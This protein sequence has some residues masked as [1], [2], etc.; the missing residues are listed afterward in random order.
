M[1][2]CVWAQTAIEQAYHDQEWCTPKLDD[3]EIFEWLVLELMQAGLSWRT[4]L[5]KR[6]AMRQAF[7]NF[8]PEIIAQ[9][10]DVKFQALME[11]AG[12][13]RN[14]LKIQSVIKNAQAYGKVQDEWG[15]FAKYIWHFVN[16]QP[17]MNQWQENSEVPSQSDLSR[18][19]S[20]SMKQYGFSFIGP[21]IAYSF[22]QAVGLV[23][24]HLIGCDYYV[25]VQEQAR[26][27]KKHFINTDG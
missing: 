17:I 8:N 25:K 16:Y 9:Y 20:K 14:R 11:N 21:T 2:N 7:D 19:V 1:G 5:D 18:A 4:I 22:I 6:E 27:V 3:R 15:S 13:I 12:I 26:L 24:D 10:D 23:N